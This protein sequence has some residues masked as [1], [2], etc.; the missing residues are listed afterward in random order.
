ML[1]A[2]DYR[3]SMLKWFKFLPHLSNKRGLSVYNFDE[4]LSLTYILSHLELFS[5]SL[6]NFLHGQCALGRKA[7][8]AKC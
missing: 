7:F 6:L 1:L 2:L 8:L 5:A 3:N 4:I